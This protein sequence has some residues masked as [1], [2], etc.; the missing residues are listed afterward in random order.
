MTSW[1]WRDVEAE[2]EA[3]ELGRLNSQEADGTIL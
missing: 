1:I 2:L 3:T